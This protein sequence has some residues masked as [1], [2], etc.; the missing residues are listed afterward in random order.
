MEQKILQ[1]NLNE[2]QVVRITLNSPKGNVLDAEMMTE[3][4]SLLDGLKNQPHV[5]LIQFIGAGKHFSF[6]AA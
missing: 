1:E 6:G 2:N 3:L 5:K 4:Q